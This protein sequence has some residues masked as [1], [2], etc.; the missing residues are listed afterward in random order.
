MIESS[1]DVAGGRAAAGELLDL[2][3]PPTAIFA[4]DDPLAIGALQAAQERGLSVPDDLSIVGFDD[5]AEAAL[6]TPAL[7]TVRQPLAEMGR[8][9][10]SLLIRLL[11]NRQLEALHIRGR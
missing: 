9:G 5:T 7:T 11:E 1:F 3:E 6:V 4:F 2:P 8:L 10:V